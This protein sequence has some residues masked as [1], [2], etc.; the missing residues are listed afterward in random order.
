MAIDITRHLRKYL[1]I[2]KQAHDQSV[3]ESET[4]LRIG[5]FFEEALGY[6]I[7][8]EVSKEHTIKN[9]YVDYAI[10]LKGKVAFLVEVKQA[11]IDLR[12]RH[13]EQASNYAANSG[14]PWVLL[15]NGRY[16]QLFRLTFDEGIQ[17]DLIWSVDI[18]DDDIKEVSNKLSLLHKRSVLKNEHEKYYA[19][20]RTLEPRSII[21]AIFQENTL[22][23]IRSH[24]KRMTGIT[25]EEED[26]VAG[27]KQMLSA[28]AWKDISDIKV[29]RPRKVTRQRQKKEEPVVPAEPVRPVE[30]AHSLSEAPSVGELIGGPDSATKES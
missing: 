23:M 30:V 18:L 9:R 22:R 29:K 14:I 26:L 15:T 10:K 7:F 24:L 11:G 5:K 12:E 16:W 8:E 28:D 2:F 25:V 1:P 20:V 27:I 6:D 4:S 3:N 21:Q 17:S 13:I 19:K